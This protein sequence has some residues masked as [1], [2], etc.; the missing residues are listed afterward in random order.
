MRKGTVINGFEQVQI[1]DIEC[2]AGIAMGQA[3][4]MG[5]MFRTIARLVED[6]DVRALC[7]H[8]VLQA[9]LLHNDVDVLQERATK[10]GLK[11]EAGYARENI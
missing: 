7:A 1:W 9:E 8:G 11:G 5:T 4:T 2:M 3:E 6:K 10:A